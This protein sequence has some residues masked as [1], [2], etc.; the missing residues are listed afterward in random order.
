MNDRTILFFAPIAGILLALIGFFIIG[1]LKP[2]S[3]RILVESNSVATVYIN[4]KRTGNTPY[5]STRSSGEVVVKLVPL[6]TS[7][8]SYESRVN[9]ASGIE[10]V[11]RVDLGSS[12]DQVSY[13]TI[14]FE[15]TGDRL[16]SISVVTIPD[17]SSVSLDGRV[18]DFSPVKI[19]NIQEGKHT[20]SISASGYLNRT[21]DVNA[22]AGYRLIVVVKLAKDPNYVSTT[23]L[24]ATPIPEPMVII[25]DTE[26][27]FLRVRQTPSA[28]GTE[29]GQVKPGEKY[30]FLSKDDTNEWEQIEL[31]DGKVG[32]VL[33]SYV[34]MD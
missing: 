8:S 6:D 23:S 24:P 20:L 27:G 12:Q 25:L 2:K 18:Y 22:I 32:W 1:S 14:S 29:I 19:N 28:V 11:L 30:K 9:L 17:A 15:A 34:K 33:G 26:V 3:A 4:G 10:T 31:G 21:F 13:D 5:E 16:S 7:L